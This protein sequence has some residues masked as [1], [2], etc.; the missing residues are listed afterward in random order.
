MA[1]VIRRSSFSVF[2]SCVMN[3]DAS[4]VPLTPLKTNDTD[5]VEVQGKCRV[6]SGNILSDPEDVARRRLQAFFGVPLW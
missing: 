3:C 4:Q 1:T 5:S 2:S 6:T